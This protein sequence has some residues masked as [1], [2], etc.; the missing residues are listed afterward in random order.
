VKPTSGKWFAV[1]TLLSWS[2]V[3]AFAAPLSAQQQFVGSVG[4][5]SSYCH[6]GGGENKG[7]YL[8]WAR[9]DYHTRAYAILVSARSTRM[10]EALTP[11]EKDASKS[12]KCTVCHSPMRAMPPPGSPSLTNIAYLD[13]GVSCENCHGA[14]GSWLRSHTRRDWTYPMRV[15]AGMRDLRNLYVRANTCVACH[16]NVPL[17]VRAAG[18]PLLTFELDRQSAQEPP[19]WPEEGLLNGPR[20]WLVGQ[21]VALREAS[22]ALSE[23]DSPDPQ[24]GAQWNALLWLLSKATAN[25]AELGA[26]SPPVENP[27][28]GVATAIREQ[29]EALARRASALRW[30]EARVDSVLQAMIASRPEFSNAVTLSPEVA[31]QRALR[32]VLALNCLDWA[33]TQGAPS[34][35]TSTALG[36][37]FEDVRNS[38]NFETAKFATDLATF[39]ATI[40][41]GPP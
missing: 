4:C 15:G 38:A 33:A 21:A 13:D 19:H 22:W 6:G 28:R 31:Y 30:D 41:G 32:L 36:K 2:S 40:K 12:D 7:Q 20:A 14:A 24:L 17:E 35:S 16:Q 39:C 5:K 18:H 11:P 8:T 27:G 34:T 1:A 3:G 29:A 26:I 25:Q 10:A 23:S 37:L 9:Q